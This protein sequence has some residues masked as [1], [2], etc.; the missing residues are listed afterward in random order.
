MRLALALAILSAAP[1]HA[2][3]CGGDFNDFVAAMSA[4]ALAQGA[5]PA[6]VKG[7]FNG[8]RIDKAVL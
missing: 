7:F 6:A 2:A 8:A 5:P 1:M 3:P 4:E